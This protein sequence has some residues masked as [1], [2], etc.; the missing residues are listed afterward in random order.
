VASQS[1]K[2]LYRPMPWNLKNRF[3]RFRPYSIT[4]ESGISWHL[5]NL[6]WSPKSAHCLAA[7][8]WQPTTNEQT[9]D[10]PII[11]HAARRQLCMRDRGAKRL[12]AHL[13]CCARLMGRMY[14]YGVGTSAVYSVS[15]LNFQVVE[16]ALHWHS[17]SI[18]F[19]WFSF[20]VQVQLH[21]RYV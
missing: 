7:V 3:T 6:Y 5:R 17:H 14:V 8:N 12:G 4:T 18:S 11:G 16:K 15:D 2:G 10:M 1:L 20:Y 19:M 21:E 9:L 13:L